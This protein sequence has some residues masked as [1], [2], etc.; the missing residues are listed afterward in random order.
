MRCLQGLR[1][2]LPL[3]A[4][5]QVY[6]EPQVHPDLPRPPRLHARSEGG[7]LGHAHT[8]WRTCSEAPGDCH[9][10]WANAGLSLVG[11]SFGVPCPQRQRWSGLGTGWQLLFVP[12][13]CRWLELNEMP[14][15][16]P[17]IEEN[18]LPSCLVNEEL[19]SPAWRLQ[20]T[21]FHL[22]ALNSSGHSAK[23]S[24]H[25]ACCWLPLWCIHSPPCK[26]AWDC[27]EFKILLVLN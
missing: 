6:R 18:P 16:C 17:P 22:L 24:L 8:S 25:P 1:P 23:S 12:S 2:S 11:M 9:G 27:F 13:R 20:E 10:P 21:R 19:P 14:P 26:P 7:W 15:R 3:W 4:E 5:L